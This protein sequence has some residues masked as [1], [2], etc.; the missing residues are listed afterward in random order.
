MHSFGSML[1][2]VEATSE[3]REMDGVCKRRQ[4][5]REKFAGEDIW[6]DGMRIHLEASQQEEAKETER[7]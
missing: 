1:A 6:I 3:S 7:R 4:L 2:R 5:G